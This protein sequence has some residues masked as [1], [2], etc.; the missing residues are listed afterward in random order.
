MY[1][2]QNKKLDKENNQY[3]ISEEFLEPTPDINQ[4]IIPHIKND[5]LLSQI[6]KNLER[7]DQIDY[8][9]G[10]QESNSNIKKN[11]NLQNFLDEKIESNESVN[12]N[13]VIF[14]NSFIQTSFIRSNLIRKFLSRNSENLL[15]KYLKRWK[16]R[17]Q[18][19]ESNNSL[20]K[21]DMISRTLQKDLSKISDEIMNNKFDFTNSLDDKK[22]LN[23]IDYRNQNRKVIENYL[24]NDNVDNEIIDKYNEKINPNQKYKY[25]SFVEDIKEDQNNNIQLNK[26]NNN[27][28]HSENSENMNNTDRLK[29]IDNSK[30]DDVNDYNHSHR[31]IRSESFRDINGNRVNKLKDNTI[32][33]SLI[34]VKKKNNDVEYTPIQYEE[35][36]FS[37]TSPNPINRENKSPLKAN[38]QNQLIQKSENITFIIKNIFIKNYRIFALMLF[39]KLYK[40]AFKEAGEINC[41]NTF[42]LFTKYSISQNKIKKLQ[43]EINERTSNQA[44]K[45]FISKVNELKLERESLIK[46]NENMINH[47][48]NECL[49][50]EQNLKEKAMIIFNKNDEIDA[51][52]EQIEILT[53]K[54]DGCKEQIELLNKKIEKLESKLNNTKLNIIEGNL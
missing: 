38:N 25:Y 31:Y 16:Y 8:R 22:N 53:Q 10:Y 47:L 14:T 3:N 54:N 13:S 6:N 12:D 7:I 42:R 23:D 35:T 29:S 33:S 11:D 49:K 9:I 1:E 28:K 46:N 4:N 20:I 24:L 41:I 50:L 26:I 30:I 21:N 43:S 36:D 17:D 34:L 39:L 48:K 18:R 32:N 2:K 37:R 19:V 52:R 51:N 44:D 27:R 5:Y 40:K 45:E 15:K